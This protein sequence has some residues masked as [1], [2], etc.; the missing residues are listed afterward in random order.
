MFKLDWNK[1]YLTISLYVCAVLALTIL[2]VTFC[3]FLPSILSAIGAFLRTLTPIFVGLALA[4]LINPLLSLTEKRLMKYVDRKKRSPYIKRII[5]LLVTY[6]LLTAVIVLFGLLIFPELIHN[7]D[8]IA[9]TIT[10]NVINLY[11]SIRAFAANTLGITL[12]DLSQTLTAIVGSLASKL[13]TVGSNVG[14][15]VFNFVIGLFLSFF[16]L[17]HNE[18]LRRGTKKLFAAILPRKAFNGV[19]RTVTMSHRVF[20]QFFVANIFDS[21][22]VG[23]I[24][25][26]ALGICHL[27]FMPSILHIPYIPLIAAIIAITNLIPYIGPYIGAVPSVLLVLIDSE[28]GF[29]RA[30]IVTLFII[31]VQLLDG[32]VIS[33]RIIGKAIGISSMWVFLSIIVFGSFWGVLGMFVAVPLFTV[34]YNLVRDLTNKRLQKK[35]LSTA[36]S[37]YE[38]GDAANEAGKFVWESDATPAPDPALLSET[39]DEE[40]LEGLSRRQFPLEKHKKEEDEE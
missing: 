6:I 16:I 5:C 22:I 35:N 28:G 40:S 39:A 1:K 34:I 10:T 8:E 32:N 36:T 33:P 25:L 24:L 2:G 26:A 37:E 23:V 18:Q 27:P 31:G 7:F 30:V 21:L 12:G 20:G 9:H 19:M 4:Y 17:L 3:V 13:G 15:W 11:E 38:P 29:V 14:R